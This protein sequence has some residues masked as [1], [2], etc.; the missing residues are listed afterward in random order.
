ME[1]NEEVKT[2][3][4]QVVEAGVLKLLASVEDFKE[5]DLK[6]LTPRLVLT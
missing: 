2:A 4:R 3:L 6:W 5:G 1:T